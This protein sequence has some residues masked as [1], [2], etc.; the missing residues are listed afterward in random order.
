MAR[1]YF[2]GLLQYHNIETLVDIRSEP[3]SKYADW[4]TKSL[5]EQELPQQGI[6]YRYLGRFLGG[7][8]PD[9]VVWKGDKVDF[10]LL[11]TQ[12]YFIEGIKELIAI[13]EKSRTAIMCSEENPL[14]CHRSLAV[15][16]SLE[17]NGIEVAHIRHGGNL[18]PESSLRPQIKLPL[19]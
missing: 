6:E 15:A 17:A 1:E 9:P 11:R 19:F 10:D 8:P 3:Y 12:E 7:K 4:A 13:A 5:L 14:H 2:I 18:Q 16:S